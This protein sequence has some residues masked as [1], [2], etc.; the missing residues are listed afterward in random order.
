VGLLGCTGF[1]L[2]AVHIALFQT[3]PFAAYNMIVAG[4][5]TVVLAVRLA[6]GGD[7]ALAFVAAGLVGL[8]VVTIDFAMHSVVRLT[9][10]GVRNADDLEPLTGLLGRDAFYRESATMIAARSRSDDRHLVIVVVSLDNFALLADTEGQLAGE[11][12]RVGVANAL[13]STT[14]SGA[15]VAHSGDDEFLIADTFDTANCTP[16]AERVRRGI[17]L[18]PGGL[19]ASIGTVAT[20]M[21]GLADCP[22]H[23]LLDELIEIATEAMLKARRA[24]GNQTGHTVCAHPRTLLDDNPPFPFETDEP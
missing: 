10:I 12:I 15:I 24:G 2:L 23:A 18:T 20:P 17:A 19:R 11:R 6:A 7:P 9:G 8:V 21:S 4:V 13:R 1:A 16:L 3:P 14:R 5:T 22:P